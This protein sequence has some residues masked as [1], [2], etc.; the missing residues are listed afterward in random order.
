MKKVLIITYYW[1]PAGG[2]AVQR[3]VK[4]A[5]T[6]P[7]FGW[8]PL[9]LTVQDPSSPSADSSLLADIPSSCNVYK[10]GTFEP[11]NLYRRLTGR[12]SGSRLPKDI[13]IKKAD[14]KLSELL[15]RMIRANVF[16]PDARVGWIP[17]MVKQGMKIIHDEKPDLIFSSSPPHSLQIGARRIARKSGLPWIADFRDPWIGAL[18]EQEIERFAPTRSMN[19]WFEKRVLRDAT[20]ITTVS[21]E[22]ASYLNHRVK[23]T[24]RTIFSGFEDRPYVAQPKDKFRI[25]YLGN[26]SRY[27]S[28]ASFLKAVRGLPEE[29]RTMIEWSVIGRVNE[30]HS[31]QI[32][33]DGQIPFTTR[34]FLPLKEMMKMGERASLLLLINPPADYDSGLISAKIFDYLALDRPI[35]AIG[36]KGGTLDQLLQETGTGKLFA[37][38]EVLLMKAFLHDQLRKWQTDPQIV[39]NKTQA[40]DTYRLTTNVE[41]LARLFETVLKH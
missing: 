35:L 28:P 5:K 33:A 27:Q 4:F 13:I 9:I 11:F 39:A 8:Q 20:A 30:A 25:F 36:K 24:Y 7:L 38:D 26:M 16:I 37:E 17:Q 15:A 41:Q 34:D 10:T 22:V 1:P 18:W 3:I 6:L 31:S 2:P 21:D 29:M 23:N 32:T 12:K 19:Q 14:E 40:L